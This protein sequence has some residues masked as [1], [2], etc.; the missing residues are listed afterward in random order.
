MAMSG[1]ADV[2]L[3]GR[4]LEWVA[5]K[6]LDVVFPRRCVGCGEFETLLCSRCAGEL[7]RLGV[8]RCKRCG[9]PGMASTAAGW[10]E[11]CV[12][13]QLQFASARSAFAY[14]GVARELV[15]KL[16]YGGQRQLARVMAE[17]AFDDFV[18]LCEELG[19]C[20]VTW[21]PTHPS[22][23]RQRGFNQ[24]EVLARELAAAVGESSVLPLVRKVRRTAHQQ[25]LGRE[26][27]AHNLA[28]AFA[29]SV[30]KNVI[31]KEGDV[32]LVDDVYT[33][34]A[35]ASAVASVIN[36]ATGRQVHVFTF[37]R[38]LGEVPCFTD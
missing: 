19:S 25:A 5:G 31:P 34:G 3:L 23:R 17:A 13:R 14:S 9:R 15:V 4:G 28:G 21:V 16:K 29:P 36:A 38:A 10:C 1:G 8:P 33:T 30:P 27:R 18:E 12:T 37:A 20:V 2:A 35:T 22:V 7:E 32:V 6:L 11:D 26:E 24:A